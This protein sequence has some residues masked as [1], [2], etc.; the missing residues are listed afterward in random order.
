MGK[1]VEAAQKALEAAISADV[2]AANNLQELTQDAAKIDQEDRIQ[3]IVDE[4]EDARRA[5]NFDKTNE[6]QSVLRGMG[7]QVN[8]GD[9]TWKATGGL[10]GTVKD[11][12]KMRP[13]DWK[14]G[15]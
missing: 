11:G 13:G 1:A 4:R 10:S 5:K 9:L 15:A 2:E 7:V 6:L 8:D 12:L 3:R 14:C